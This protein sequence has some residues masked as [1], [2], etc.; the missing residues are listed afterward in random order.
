[1]TG[2]FRRFTDNSIIRPALVRAGPVAVVRSLGCSRSL[3]LLKTRPVEIE[4]G[5]SP[6]AAAQHSSPMLLSL[7]IVST[8]RFHF[9]REQVVSEARV[10]LCHF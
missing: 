9:S 10:Q 1:M 2:R 7:A 5:D 3:N 8:L 4:S 6:G